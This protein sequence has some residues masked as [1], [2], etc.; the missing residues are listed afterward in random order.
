MADLQG[1]FGWSQTPEAGNF[2]RLQ[3]VRSLFFQLQSLQKILYRDLK[4][5][6]KCLKTHSSGPFY[7]KQQF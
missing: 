3:G 7:E 1:H 4:W 6:K 5:K 2:A